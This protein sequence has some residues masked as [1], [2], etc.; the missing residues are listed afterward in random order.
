MSFFYK[1][2][3]FNSAK[4][5]KTRHFYIY[6]HASY[7]LKTKHFILSQVF[8]GNFPERLFV[9]EAILNL[10]AAYKEELE[11]LGAKIK[12]RNSK[13]EKPYTFLLP[14]KIPNYIAI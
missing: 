6:F 4:N 9:E 13:L 2:S 3:S 5:C 7:F 14:E 12:E 10:Q 11:Q 1:I 8:I